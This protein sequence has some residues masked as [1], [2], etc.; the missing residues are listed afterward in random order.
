M[1]DGLEGRPRLKAAVLKRFRGC[2]PLIALVS[3]LLPVAG[4]AHA[5]AAPP[6]PA[7]VHVD[8]GSPAAKEYAIPLA[9]ARGGAA[10]R[11]Q[12]FGSGITRAPS[13]STTSTTSS[14]TTGGTTSAAVTTKARPRPRAHHGSGSRPRSSPKPQ[15]RDVTSAPAAELSGSTRPAGGGAGIAWMLGVAALVLALGGLGGAV[16]ARYSR[17]TSTRTS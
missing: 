4:P 2:V 13:T 3:L 11:G 7:G 9:Q 17:G 14:S 10:G 6:L 5:A 15:V 16:L 8:P 1:R 12:L